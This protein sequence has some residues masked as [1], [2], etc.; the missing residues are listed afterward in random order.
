VLLLFTAM[1][2]KDFDALFALFDPVALEEVLGALSL[3]DAKEALAATMFD[4]GSIEFSGLEFGTEVTSDTTATVTVVAGTVTMV[5]FEG[6]TDTEDVTT[7]G[8]PV[9]FAIVE[10]EGAWYLDPTAMFGS[11]M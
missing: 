6:V 3:E 8:Q 9:T 5:D 4:Y 11:T 10:R 2:N 7:A 1:E